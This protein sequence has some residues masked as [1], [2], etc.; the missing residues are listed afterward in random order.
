M[1]NEER[2]ILHGPSCPLFVGQREPFL[3]V[4]VDVSTNI[5]VDPPLGRD[6]ILKMNRLYEVHL[7]TRFLGKFKREGRLSLSYTQLTSNRIGVVRV[8]LR[9]KHIEDGPVFLSRAFS[10][11]CLLSSSC[12]WR[13]IRCRRS[14]RREPTLTMMMCVFVPAA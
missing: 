13:E 8:P 14:R 2:L 11:A 5:F 3:L 4:C 9:D 12:G 1:K 6:W 7:P 10:V